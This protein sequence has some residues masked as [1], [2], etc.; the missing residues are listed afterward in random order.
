LIVTL[1]ECCEKCRTS[2]Q[3]PNMLIWCMFM[4]SAMVVPLLLL[5]NTVGGVLCAEFRIV[6]CSTRCS[7]KTWRNRK[8][9][10]IWYSVAILLAREDSARIGVSRTR[11][12]RTLH[13]DGLYPFHPQPVQNLRPGDSAMRLEFCHWLHTNRQLLPLILFTDEATFTRNGI[14]NTHNS[15]R[16]SHENAHGTVETN[17]QRRFSI[18]VWCGMIGDMLIGP[19]IFRRS[20]DRTKLPRISAKW[21]TKTTRG[22][23]FAYTDCCVL[24][25]ERSPFSLY[26][27]RDATSQWHFP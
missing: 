16:W 8:T 1:L 26:P 23:S 12:W 21:I 5:K 17:F 27:T 6:E 18:N 13:E 24:S 9:F 22:C 15:H 7:N 3:M 19:V 11:E 20:Y 4:A 10:L 2:S 14:N 25:A